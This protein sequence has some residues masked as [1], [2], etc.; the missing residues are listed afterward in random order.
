MNKQELIEKI[1]AKKEFSQLPLE[2][3]ELALEKFENKGL[4]DYQKFKMAR[5]F[6]RKIFLGFSSRKIFS[7]PE[8]ETEWYLMK[9]KSTKERHLHYKEIYSRCLKGFK[10]ASVIDLGAGINGLS[11]EFFLKEGVKVNYIAVEAIGQFVELMNDFFKKK[12]FSAKAYHL[13]LFN[14]EKIKEIIKKQKSPRVIFLFKVIDSLELVKRDYSKELLKEISGLSERIVISFATKSLGAR[15]RFSV[16]R[17]WIL[18]FIQD[19]FEILED[20]EIEGERYV[21]FQNKV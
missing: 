7:F 8:K 15:K 20:F 10:S 21:S 12:N 6:L 19:N 11:C 1:V 16:Q 14:L 4:N 13:S 9:H 17:T 2:D 5:Q 3:V 18:R